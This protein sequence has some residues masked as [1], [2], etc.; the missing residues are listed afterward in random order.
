MA[1]TDSTVPKDNPFMACGVS[2][3]ALMTNLQR[4][5]PEWAPAVLDDC[6]TQRLEAI[7]RQASNAKD[8]LST[9]LKALGNVLS[10]LRDEQVD[11]SDVR[12]CG[13]LISE[14][15][16]LMHAC[17]AYEENAR[18]VLAHGPL[19]GLKEGGAA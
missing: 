6:E 12:G 2:L 1:N 9:G 7:A 5:P 14:L 11:A 3:A 19:L 15:S 8:C 13:W 4:H 18:H 16:D 17:D 10:V